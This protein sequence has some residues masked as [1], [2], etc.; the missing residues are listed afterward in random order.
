[1]A[2]VEVPVVDITVPGT[3]EKRFFVGSE[4][5]DGDC[6]GMFTE[7]G[8]DFTLVVANRLKVY[9]ATLGRKVSTLNA[10]LRVWLDYL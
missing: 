8:D 3:G 6:R 2:C 4:S 10:V 5:E 9:A 7:G 1:M